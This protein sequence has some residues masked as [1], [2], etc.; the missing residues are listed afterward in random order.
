MA[1]NVA[2]AA[3]GTV[4]ALNEARV[5]TMVTEGVSSNENFGST[6][7]SQ[8]ILDTRQ[9]A[10]CSSFKSLLET[11]VNF[12]TLWQ[13][14]PKS[15]CV[16]VREKCDSLPSADVKRVVLRSSKKNWA[17]FKTDKLHNAV[18]RVKIEMQKYFQYSQ[19]FRFRTLMCYNNC[20]R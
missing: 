15:N 20:I 4:L 17:S 13:Y 5:G 10:V 7:R 9:D 11:V 1:S 18:D 3:P 6:F 2:I 19:V 16:M 8:T 14:M 12:D